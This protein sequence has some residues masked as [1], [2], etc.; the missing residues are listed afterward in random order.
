ME[1]EVIPFEFRLT[2]F[3]YFKLHPG[4]ALKIQNPKSKTILGIKGWGLGQGDF[5]S[6]CPRLLASPCLFSD[7]EGVVG[8]VGE[9]V[10][11]SVVGLVGEWVVGS[12]VGLVVEW[13][14]E[15][16]VGLAFE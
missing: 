8:L 12:I 15:W 13:A 2:T 7:V 10:V 1:R 11:G 3:D 4:E 14:V 6:L 9:W 5:P 16:V